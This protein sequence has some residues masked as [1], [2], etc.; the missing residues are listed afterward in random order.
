MK[1]HV[2]GQDAMG[3]DDHV[4]LAFLQ[5]AQDFLLFGFHDKAVQHFHTDRE[6]LEAL[7]RRGG[8]LQGEDRGRAQESDLL[9]FGNRLERCS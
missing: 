1:L 7:H 5:L 2:F 4:N 8:M 6:V 9:A 3:A